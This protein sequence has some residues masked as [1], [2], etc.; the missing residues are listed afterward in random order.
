MV[1]I[2]FSCFFF[3]EYKS[4]MEK[5]GTLIFLYQSYTNVK[6]ILITIGRHI[7]K[8]MEPK[9]RKRKRVGEECGNIS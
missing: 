9:D 3:F 5:N 2:D 6:T 1:D 4:G 8:I 7:Y